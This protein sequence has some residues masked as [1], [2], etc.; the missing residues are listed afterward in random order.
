MYRSRAA[1]P[2]GDARASLEPLVPVRRVVRH[3]VDDEADAR[4]VHRR[5][6]DVEVRERAE[7]GVDVAVVV[8]VVP[9]VGEG[10]RVER[11]EPHRVDPELHEVRDAARDAGEV[12]DAVAVRVGEAA[13]VDLVDGGLA[14]PGRVAREHDGCLGRAGVGGRV[15][16]SVPCSFPGGCVRVDASVPGGCP[17]PHDT[18]IAGTR[19]PPPGSSAQG[20]A[21]RSLT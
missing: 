15:G 4:G 8:D 19:H 14:P 20:M 18:P 11:R 7:L 17:A 16:H 10:R 3:D 21:R 12:A 5:D 6:H 13:R 9:A 2:R 1:D